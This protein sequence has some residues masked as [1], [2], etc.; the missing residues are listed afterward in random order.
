[1][2]KIL[3][4]LCVT[5]LSFSVIRAQVID[6]ADKQA[7]LR[8]VEANK[9][10]IGLSATD[11]SNVFVSDSYQSAGTDITMVYLQQ[12]HLG[13]PVY[14]KMLV[15]AFRNGK[16]VSNAGKLISQI[17][18][19]ANSSVPSIGETE[20]VRMAFKEENLAGPV[21]YGSKK[22]AD[23]RRNDYGQLPGTYENVTSELV[24]YPVESANEISVKL[25]WQIIIAPNGKDDI[26][27]LT[28]DAATGKILDKINRVIYEDFDQHRIKERYSAAVGTLPS[29][30]VKGS[31][32]DEKNSFERLQYRPS[33][34]S[35]VNYK[36]IPYPYEAPS[37]T[38]AATVTNP[39][40][41]APGNAT[42]L[43]WHSN[44]TTDYTISRGNN[45]W[46]TEDTLGTN[47][48]NGRPAYSSTTP[49]PLNFI[50]TPN[51]NVEPSRDSTMQQFCITNLFYWNNTIH[52][53][54]YQYGFDEPA[55]NFQENNQGRGGQGNDHVMALAQSGAAGHIGNNANFSTPVDGNRPRMRMY[56]FNPAPILQIN[57]PPAIAGNYISVEGAMSTNNLLAN[58]GPVTGQVIYYNDDAAGT[59]HYACNPPAN[60]VTGKIALIDRGFGG[61][62]CTATVPF[63]V[64]VKNA[65]NAGAIAVIMVNNVAGPPITMGGTDNTI[66]IPAV[67]VSQSDGAIFAAQL[68]NNVNAT[69]SV[70]Q[71]LDGDLDAGIICHEYTHGISNRLTGG[72]AT[73]SCLNNAEQAGEGW[74]DYFGLMMTTN[75]PLVTVNSG[76]TSRPVGTYVFGQP[77]NG[78]GIRNYPYTTNITTNP[79]TYAHM[80]VTGAPWLFSNGSEVH[81]IGEIWC[82]A[83]WE[84]T[85]GIIQQQN[86]INPNLYD[87]SLANPGGN[88]IAFK[89][90]MEGMKLQPCSPGFIDA[91]NAI[92]TADK[93]LY[94]GAHQCAIWTAF[95]K[96]G[97]GYSA[98]QGSANST[99]DQTA[100][101]DLPPAPV[102]T[103]QPSDVT[104][105][106]GAN[107]SF[108]VANNPATNGAYILYQW[109]LSTDGGTTWNNITNGGVY[110]GATTATLTLTAVTAGMNGY[111]YRCLLRQG[112]ATT[113]SNVATLTVNLPAGFTFNSPAPVVSNCPAPASMTST[114]LTA[115]YVGGFTGNIALTATGNPG[116]TT[117][118]FSTNPL[119]T[120]NNSTT[121]TLNNTNTLAPGSYVV[122]VTGTSAPATPQTQNITF[123]I[124]P[125]TGPAITAQ[126]ANQTLCAGGNTS[127]SITSATATSFQWQVSTDGG[128]TYNNVTN[129]GVYTGAT[130]ATL[131]LTGVTGAMNGYRYRCIAT[132]VCGST[133]SNAAILTVNTPPSI[134]TQ[135]AN[136][137]GCVGGN[138]TVSVVVT[139]T[140]LTYQWQLSTDGGTTFNNIPGATASS[141]TITGLTLAMNGYKYQCIITGVCPVSPITTNVATLT[142]VTALNITGQPA[143][144]TV[145][146]GSPASFTV[147]ASGA[148]TYQWQISVDGGVTWTDISGATSATYTIAST[149]AAMNGNKFRCN[150][151]SP[152]GNAT[153]TVAT[154]TV[155]TLP[156]ITAQPSSA[157][158][159]AGA[160]NTFS[161]TATGTGITYQWQISNNG[162]SGPW[163]NIPGATASTYTLT[164]I[165]AAQNNTAYQC[166][167]TGVCSPPATSNCALLTV[168]TSVN[169]TSQPNNQTVCEGGNT[170][171]TVAG[172]GTGI[173]Y[174]WQVSID[175]GSTWNNITNGGVYSGA[176]SA[177]LNITGANAAMNNYRYR[178]Q[179]SNATCT[180][181]GIS[182]AA[183]LTVNSVPAVSTQPQSAAVCLGGS[184][185]FSLVASGTAITYQWQLSTDGGATWNNI[186][187]A[188]TSSYTV[189]GATAAMNGYRY[190]CIVSGT[191]TPAATSAVAIFTV[192]TPVAI[193]AHPVS[194]NI[195]ATGTTSFS[196]T[197]TGT[198]PGYQWQVSTDG[199]TTWTN[200]A[201]GGVYSGA[202]TATLTL[203][204]ITA[205]M[206]SNRYRCIVSGAAPCGSLNSNNATLN[207]TPQPVITASPYTSLLPGQT[208]TLTVNVAPGPG[209]TFAWYLN[210][211]LIPG[212]TGNSVSATIS[213][214]GNY[215][216][217]VTNATGSCQSAVVSIDASI[218]NHLFIFPSP[219]D[220]QFNVTYYN[221]GGASSQRR[222]IIMNADGQMAYDRMFSIS[223]QYTLLNV[224]M[225]RAAT[226]IYVVEV[227]DNSGR[228]LAEGKVH[229]R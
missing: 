62:V 49:D 163:S 101:F 89:I 91:R 120:V 171:F 126:P 184:N 158:L 81:N 139:G 154:L 30:P 9:T 36:V 68:G 222:I 73:T 179:L 197:A 4:S 103:T 105:L 60:S 153:T 88:T 14:N 182:N 112:C 69:L 104:V 228:K 75:W 188:T 216:V 225:R 135:P 2:K 217:T 67:M 208:T 56:L 43:G 107:T 172:S 6:N 189:S 16:L 39:W 53:M 31:F 26:W 170:S 29:G 118:T 218:S 159:C 226:G 160:N 32:F 199:G 87:F 63:T 198:S 21:I 127:F 167:V 125:G 220:G 37:F 121:V 180:T 52:D 117:V 191:C 187:G 55:G 111:K 164:N 213:Q 45:V 1:M 138:A 129:G 143:D 80:G 8:L 24:W 147:T 161:V 48:N 46:A 229:V 195:C 221:N 95:A 74:S 84:M 99:T 27:Q 23:G 100:A 44:G 77:N 66:T 83:L 25:A 146:E 19:L 207:V 41:L 65:Q 50:T 134:T 181:P 119:T 13:I 145:C 3:L 15:L 7:A 115:T 193:T 34:V 70:S 113:T 215:S 97:M 209:L 28:I 142:V 85:W 131:S 12:S 151:T 150:I 76:L 86:N 173:I 166:I 148:S 149:T 157:T 93:N 140:S 47:T 156:A 102:I 202:T 109:Q 116:G 212:A 64:K 94:A 128:A 123:T 196:V 57:T 168:V 183:I 11:M 18:N 22:S 51:Y 162:C 192:N 59:T 130:T 177:T 90:V 200:V 178:C 40:A 176:T 78:P 211:T 175:G 206:N 17:S 124:N 201:N 169:V 20:A 141:Y 165:T 114:N 137:S 106:V 10:E 96:R 136:P 54:A 110:S 35:I 219:N 214:L 224:D 210:G 186:A 72:P 82:V 71:V 108:T 133:T 132:T 203:T 98:V 5:L 155:N 190:R 122:A 144:L 58:V 42:S 185:T 194:I 227:F 33:L 204:G 61:P 38:T 79:L 205:N 174:Q 223:G 152:C 92:L